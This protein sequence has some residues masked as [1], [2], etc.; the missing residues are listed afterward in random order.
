VAA[1]V[2]QAAV[3]GTVLIMALVAA[4]MEAVVLAAVVIKV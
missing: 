1:L 3:A 4:Q 2:A